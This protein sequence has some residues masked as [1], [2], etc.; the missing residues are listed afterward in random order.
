MQHLK[1]LT[2]LDKLIFKKNHEI[3]LVVHLHLYNSYS[4]HFIYL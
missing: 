3:L 4:Q 2:L 1:K